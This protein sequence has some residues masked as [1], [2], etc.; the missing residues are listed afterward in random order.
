M[1]N[2]KNQ[3]NGVSINKEF[4]RKFSNRYNFR[5]LNSFTHR[6]SIR[7]Q[8]S[9]PNM[10]ESHSISILSPTALSSSQSSR[11]DRFSD[12]RIPFFGGGILYY[13]FCQSFRQRDFDDVWL[14]M[15]KSNDEQEG[16][17]SWGWSKVTSL[18]QSEP[19]A[20]FDDSSTVLRYDEDTNKVFRSTTW[21]KLVY[22]NAIS[23]QVFPHK[24][25]LVSLKDMGEEG[26]TKSQRT[27][28]Q[29]N[30]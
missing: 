27:S 28:G 13:A 15:K 2:K 3:K 20:F 4:Q 5:H 14:L 8:V 26:A 16:H 1:G 22:V 9:L 29:I 7:M 17:Q 12:K 11:F 10:E 6:I 24:H 21:E 30:C 23:C 18:E 19:F 25:T